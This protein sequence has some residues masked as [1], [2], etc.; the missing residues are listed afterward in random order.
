MAVPAPPANAYSLCLAGIFLGDKL[1]R[2]PIM[3]KTMA[4]IWKPGR[5]VKIEDLNDGHYLFRFQ[6]EVDICRVMKDGPWNFN[7]SLLILHELKPGEKPKSVPFTKVPF[8]VQV[9]DIPFDHFS[10]ATGKILGDKVGRYLNYD[11]INKV[12]LWPDQYMRIQVELD[13]RQPLRKSKNLHGDIT[14]TCTFTYERLQTFC[15]IC[16]I[17]GHAEKYCETHYHLPADQITRRWDDSISAEGR[18]EH[19]NR[20]ARWLKNSNPSGGTRSLGQARRQGLG[21]PALARAIPTNI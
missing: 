12:H 7:G 8:W 21:T 1:I 9:H 14:T 3:Q 15:F 13:V 18:D 10:E 17:M 20:A 4:L 2:F 11:P 19:T 16:G 6:H 5:G